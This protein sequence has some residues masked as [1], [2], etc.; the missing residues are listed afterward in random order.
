MRLRSTAAGTVIKFRT[1]AVTTA[2]DIRRSSQSSR[3]RFAR[4]SK[5][6]GHS[7]ES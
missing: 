2:S 6:A 4:I 5:R 1:S 7:R 3:A